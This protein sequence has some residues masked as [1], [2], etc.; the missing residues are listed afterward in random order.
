MINILNKNNLLLVGNIMLINKKN[1]IFLLSMLSTLLVA[2]NDDNDHSNVDQPVEAKP[3][4]FP[5]R[6]VML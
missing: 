3:L 2:C 5:Q 4:E 1:Q 6:E